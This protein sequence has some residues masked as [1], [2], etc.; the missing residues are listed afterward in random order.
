MNYFEE[1]FSKLSKLNSFD[2]TAFYPDK[3]VS[4]DVCGFVLT[5]SLV[6]TDV[7]NI[8]MLFGCVIDSRPKGEPEIKKE[9]GEYNGLINFLNKLNISILHELFIFINENKAVLEEKF[10]KEV[11]KSI[12]KDEKQ[13]WNLLVDTALDRGNSDKFYKDLMLIRNKISFHYDRKIILKGYEHMFSDMNFVDR[14]YISR[15][16]NMEQ[17]RFYFADG[18]VESYIHSLTEFDDI[19]KLYNPIRNYTQKLNTSIWYIV[20]NFIQKR[21]FGFR[22]ENK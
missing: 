11:I 1:C 9:W 7:K 6:Y 17:T 12:K 14:P 15:G 21:G 13:S 5:L 2:K 22:D 3:N 10:F 8:N 20:I 4:S 18:A 19:E 16:T